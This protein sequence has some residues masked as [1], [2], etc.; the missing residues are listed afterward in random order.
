MED[1]CISDK[2]KGK[3]KNEDQKNGGADCCGLTVDG[4]RF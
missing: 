3:M 4:M 2:S 1:S